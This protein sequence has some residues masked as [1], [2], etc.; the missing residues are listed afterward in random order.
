MINEPWFEAVAGLRTGSCELE[1][2]PVSLSTTYRDRIIIII[3]HADGYNNAMLSNSI[4]QR[5]Q[6]S[7]SSSS[8]RQSVTIKVIN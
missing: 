2:G 3:I 4:N 7:G 6:T 8:S 5:K 1:A